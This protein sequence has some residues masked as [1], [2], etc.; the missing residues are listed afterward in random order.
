MT[1]A[2]PPMVSGGLPVLGHLVEMLRNR[3]GLFKRGHA[4]HGDIFAMKLGPQPVL[5]ITGA[6]HNRQFYTETDKTL[7]M[8]DGYAFLKEAIGEVLFTAST[9]SY[10]NQRP[11]LQEVFRR[12]RMVGYI[13]AMNIE[14]QHWLDTLGDSGEVDIM[15]EMLHLAQ[16]VAGRALI[17][18]DYQQEL[19]AEFWQDYAAISASLD[20][21][22]PPTLPLPKFRRRDQAKQKIS[23]TLSRLIDKRRAHPE[24][25]DDLIS[26]LLTTP[27]KDGTILPD[28]TIVT[29][30]MGLLFAG[31][32]TTAGQ[33]A[34]LLALLLQHPDY[35]DLVKAEIAERVPA[36]K[37]LDAATLSSLDHIYWAIDE[38]TRLRPSA[39][40]QMRTVD[41]P[42]KIGDYTIPKGW[43]LMVSA[44]TSHFLPTV[45]DNP[46]AFDPL[47]YLPERGE[48]K[49]S[50]AIVGFGGGIHKCTGMNFA[51][52][53]MAIITALLFQQFDVELLSRE[54]HVVSGNGANHPSPVRVRY[55]RKAGVR[56]L[57]LTMLEAAAAGCPHHQ[58]PVSAAQVE[59]A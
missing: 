49:N 54:V 2:L 36:G 14:I 43:R 31:H 5:V 24:R 42:L 26:T 53:E 18:P 13:Q 38:T 4:E 1:A 30:F 20:P 29:M 10:Y 59:Q 19:G 34:W 58:Q 22:L 45:F 57:D 39:D 27:L 35:L 55:Q 47:R 50:F 9:E 8:Q 17:G 46:E 41:E 28:E 25:Y 15:Q 51:K 48:G 23:A 11:A 7:N 33:A 37:A 56:P 32:E 21:V 6:E 16:F 44:A 12:E 40:T 3:D 52:N